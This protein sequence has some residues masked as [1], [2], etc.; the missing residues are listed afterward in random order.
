MAARE[1]L[2]RI[3]SLY[4]AGLE[5]PQPI[6][7]G[8]ENGDGVDSL[9]G[10]DVSKVKGHGGI[11]FDYY[12]VVFDPHKI[13]PE[14]AILGSL[15]DDILDIFRDV[16]TGLR[17]FESGNR[18]AA[19]WEWGIHFKNHWGRHAVCAIHSLHVWLTENAPEHLSADN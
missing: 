2:I 16:V 14:E 18:S 9:P 5:L 15:D 13:P 17:V 4:I 3:T 7:G 10:S 6:A 11:P 1:A 19:L 12:R 8:A